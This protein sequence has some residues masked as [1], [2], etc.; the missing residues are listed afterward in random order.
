MGDLKDILWEGSSFEDLLEFPDSARHDMGYQ[1]HLVQ[2]G[3]MPDDWKTLNN[4][5]KGVSRCC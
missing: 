4:L 2:S 3:E 1:L 5:G